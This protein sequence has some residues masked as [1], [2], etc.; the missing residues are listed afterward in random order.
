MLTFP[1][2]QSPYAFALVEYTLPS[3]SSIKDSNISQAK[4][5][6]FLCLSHTCFH[7]K[8]KTIYHSDCW[9]ICFPLNWKIL[10]SS[11][12]LYFFS[13]NIMH[14]T[15]CLRISTCSIIIIII[16]ILNKCLLNEKPF[17]SDDLPSSI[18]QHAIQAP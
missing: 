14:L 2:T 6:L 1:I 16:I 11:H 4:I 8:H 13:L 9:H 18:T 3:D 7:E 15:L 12:I 17:K 5:A 10:E